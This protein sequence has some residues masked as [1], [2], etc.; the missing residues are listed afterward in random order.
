MVDIS[1]SAAGL[2][3]AGEVPGKNSPDPYLAQRQF[4]FDYRE[5]GCAL[6]RDRRRGPDQEFTPAPPRQAAPD[7]GAVARFRGAGGW[8]SCLW[9]NRGRGGYNCMTV[10]GDRPSQEHTGSMSQQFARSTPAHGVLRPLIG[11]PR[12]AIEAGRFANGMPFVRLAGG[13]RPM[14]VVPG[15]SDALLD[16][17]SIRRRLAWYYRAW[18][19]EFTVYVI[20]RRRD[21]PAGLT[22]DDLAAAYADALVEIIARDQPSDQRIDIVGISLGGLIGLALARDHGATVRRLVLAVAGHRPGPAAAGIAARWLGLARG[23][24]WLGLYLDIAGVTF[25]GWRRAGYRALIVGLAPW[26]ARPPAAPDDLERMVSAATRFEI[27]Q[28]LDRITTPTLVIGGTEDPI[29]PPTQLTETVDRLPNASLILF[30]GAGHG[31]FDEE[32]RAFDAAVLDFLTE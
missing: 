1:A 30:E 13:P 14:V 27:T 21:L 9:T 8:V 32:K 26:L 25:R 2:R 10:A 20:S 19:R 7:R 16:V 5:H 6:F 4:Y 15:L 23:R 28:D 22:L 18:R 3:E 12:S 11:R 17:S 24:R 29:F 31:L